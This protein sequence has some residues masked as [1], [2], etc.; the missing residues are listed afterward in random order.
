MTTRQEFADWSLFPYDH[1]GVSLEMRR[2]VGGS[3]WVYLVVG[4]QRVPIR[5]VTW[6]FAGEEEVSLLVGAYASR[7]VK[8]G[9]ELV[10]VFKQLEVEFR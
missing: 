1:Y 5:E 3:L 4:I 6:A 2:E 9:P 8:E 10:V 7:P